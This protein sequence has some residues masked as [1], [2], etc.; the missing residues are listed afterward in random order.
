[1]N[2]RNCDFCLSSNPIPFQ[3]PPHPLWHYHMNSTTAPINV[4]LFDQKGE[5]Q[6]LKP[7]EPPSPPTPTLKSETKPEAD[8]QAPAASA[9]SSAGQKIDKSFDFK[10]GNICYQPCRTNTFLNKSKAKPETSQRIPVTANHNIETPQTETRSK[11]GIRKK[12]YKNGPQSPVSHTSFVFQ[13]IDPNIINGHKPTARLSPRRFYNEHPNQLDCNVGR[14]K[15]SQSVPVPY[16]K[17]CGG[18]QVRRKPSLHK[19]AT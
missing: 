15:Q 12:T 11:R 13:D 7:S 5:P 19:T 8:K 4:W 6:H 16:D 9:A 3:L 14:V 10:H 1:M 17:I 18:N 2:L